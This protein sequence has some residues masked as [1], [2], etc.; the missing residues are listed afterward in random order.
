LNSTPKIIRKIII[1]GG[2][3]GGH[4]FPGI[5]V[6]EAVLQNFP[7]SK[8]LFIGTERQIDTK[9]LQD[10][11]FE[12]IALRCRGLKG[13]GPFGKI[14][15]LIQLPV[16]LA[17]AAGIIRR[18]KPD[19]VFGVGGYVT[20][21]VIV[22]ARLLGVPT[23]IHEQNSIPGLANRALGKVAGRICISLPGS[24][25]YFP[26]RKTVLTGNPVRRE[27]LAAAAAAPAAAKKTS[28]LLVL[29]GSQG[30][31]RLN[32]LILEAIAAQRH[33][34][35]EDFMVIHQTGTNDEE[36]VRA[37]YK[38]LGVQSQTA[39]FFKDMAPLYQAADLVVS[40]AGAT[41]LAELMVFKKPAILVPFPHAADNHQEKNAGLLVDKGCA[42]LLIESEITGSLF[43]EEIMKLLADGKQLSKM[44]AKAAGLAQPQ[45]AELILK[46]CLEILR[47]V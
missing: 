16:S 46:N 36:E 24:E 5:A 15:T 43:G 11:P 8:V 42:R 40:R 23:C 17:A 2:G 19:L 20:G 6:A 30:A 22:A 45:A 12:R 41:T 4:L 3:T 35:P 33:R 28:T 9:A 1:T 31:H 38:Q 13:L 10:K 32:L 39:A 37:R 34:L 29:G 25:T 44:S 18:F 27:L 7:A 47:D 21:P 26:R 14:L